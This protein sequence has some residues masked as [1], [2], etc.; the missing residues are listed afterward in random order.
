MHQIMLMKIDARTK[1][2]KLQ[3]QQ[4]VSPRSVALIMPKE[5]SEAEVRKIFFRE[6]ELR[7]ESIQ[8]L[9]KTA[10]E[11]FE[12]KMLVLDTL[13]IDK[14]NNEFTIEPEDYNLG[15][16]QHNLLSDEKV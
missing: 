16:I 5:M 11:D 15:V 13:L 4:G 10:D 6:Q 9:E 3:E 8:E 1:E 12:E 14:I 2:A 7:I